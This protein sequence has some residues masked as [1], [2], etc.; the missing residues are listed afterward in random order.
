[1]K[2]AQRRYSIDSS[3]IR[4]IFDLAAKLEN[5]CNLSIGLP[6]YDVPEEVK[7]AAIEAIRGGKNRY[8]LTAGVPALREKIKARYAER[9]HPVEDAIVVAGTSGGL[10]LTFMA[11]LDP[12]DELMFA[13]PYFVM[14]KH[15]CRF[16]GAVPAYVD[17][18]PDFRLRREA[19]ERAWSPRCKAIVVNSPNNP[20]GIVYSRDELKMVAEF[21]AEKNLVLITDEIYEDFVYD[22]PFDS[23]ANYS[24]PAR[25]VI[26]SGLSKNVAMTGWRLGWVGG[27]KAL[28]QALSDIQQYSFVCA[29]SPAQAAAF[30]GM[31]YDM[32]ANRRTFGQRRDAI[33]SGL[34]DLGYE[35]AKPGGAFYIFP[36]A[37]NGDG[38]AFVQRAI[39]NRLLIVPGSVFSERKTHF[40]ISFAADMK[41]IERGLGI[42]AELREPAA[43][44]T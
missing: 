14:Y 5:P 19:L 36:K 6:D 27:P 17:T 25:T 18:Y 41:M 26:I 38:D 1:L 20:T 7:E 30:A 29:P 24:D 22:G 40:R 12:G 8:T 23:P 37:P 15:L 21:A 11:L 32:A 35:V 2:L 16:I 43:V 9:G 39:E 33:F 31:D 3:G 42:F 34:R 28:I 4:K 44:R 13:D 10:F